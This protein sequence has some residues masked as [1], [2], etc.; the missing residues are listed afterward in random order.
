MVGR[1]PAVH[2]NPECTPEE[3]DNPDSVWTP[4]TACCIVQSRGPSC[5]FLPVSL[6]HLTDVLWHPQFWIELNFWFIALQNVVSSLRAE[7]RHRIEGE[8]KFSWIQY[9]STQ[10]EWGFIMSIRYN[11]LNLWETRF[12]LRKEG[13]WESLHTLNEEFLELSPIFKR[14]W[15]TH[16]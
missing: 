7:G 10:R 16:M 1:G 3:E 13:L 11:D 2:R 6:S 9:F 15:M 4:L 5:L 12:P 8:E 14:Y